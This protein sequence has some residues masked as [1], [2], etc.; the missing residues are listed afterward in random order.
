MSKFEKVEENPPNPPSQNEKDC[1]CGVFSHTGDC[2][3]TNPAWTKS[4]NKDEQ[5]HVDAHFAMNALKKQKELENKVG[6]SLYKS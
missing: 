1:E 3:H 6:S 2:M 5:E 4:H